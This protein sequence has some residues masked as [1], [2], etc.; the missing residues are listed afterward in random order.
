MTQRYVSPSNIA[1]IYI[2]LK[3][4]DRAFAWLE[5]AYEHHSYWMASLKV[6]PL[7]DDLRSNVRCGELLKRIRFGS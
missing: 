6:L 4:N 1:L 3:E 7:L 2:G 5:R